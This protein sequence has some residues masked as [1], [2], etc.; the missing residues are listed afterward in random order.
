MKF[1]EGKVG[2][3][4]VLKLDDG[5]K[6]PDV[7]ETF[8]TER[9]VRQGMCI[10]VGGINSGGRIVAGPE[11]GDDTPVVPMLFPLP[12]IHEILAVG[13]IFPDESGAPGLHM[14][15]ALGRGRNTLAGCVR[16]GIKTWKIGEVV[17]L[18]IL[19][20]SAVRKKDAKTGFSI[21]EP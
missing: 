15:G 8:A 6:I 2:R 7:I 17:L 20:T 10:L 1:S 5:D 18:E 13:T 16:P 21:L 11:K 3:V 4:F 12:G 9:G 14:H 19:G